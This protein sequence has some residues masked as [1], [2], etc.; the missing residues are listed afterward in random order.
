MTGPRTQPTRPLDLPFSERERSG[1][2]GLVAVAA[3]DV[4]RGLRGH[5][6]GAAGGAGVQAG[7]HMG[8]RE[9]G[10]RRNTERCKE[11]GTGRGAHHPYLRCPCDA[12]HL[13]RDL[14]LWK[15][16]GGGERARCVHSM[17]PVAILNLVAAHVQKN[18]QTAPTFHVQKIF[19]LFYPDIVCPSSKRAPD[20]V[21]RG[22]QHCALER[23]TAPLS[24][25]Q[26]KPRAGYR[27]RVKILRSQETNSAC[28]PLSPRT[29]EA[30][31]GRRWVDG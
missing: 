12:A 22:T 28:L 21:A 31:W 27:T 5:D 25:R 30:H 6:G 16:R 8:H 26:E 15:R 18:T 13:D 14:Y 20:G 2:E 17:R 7:A 11:E 10:C 19:S 1:L 3:V 4:V 29:L 9:A 24:G 23:D